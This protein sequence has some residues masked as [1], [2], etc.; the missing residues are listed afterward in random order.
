MCIK[1]TTFAFAYGNERKE[2]FAKSK[3]WHAMTMTDDAIQCR[4][5]PVYTGFFL[6]V[7]S[8]NRNQVLFAFCPLTHSLARLSSSLL[9]ADCL[10]EMS[11]RKNKLRFDE[12]QILPQRHRT[13]R[14]KRSW[15]V[16]Y[17]A[18]LFFPLFSSSDERNE[19]SL[20]FVF[21]W[22]IR[23]WPFIRSDILTWNSIV[24]PCTP[25]RGHGDHGCNSLICNNVLLP[26][27]CV[28]LDGNAEVANSVCYEYG[29]VRL[30]LKCV[31]IRTS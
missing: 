30:H 25:C 3:N 19:A 7:V 10:M 11:C 21:C 23:N 15:H 31:Y 22:I 29:N 12:H 27:E 13:M 28:P 16:I 5:N 18:L 24:C 2:L 4:E 17:S 26:L 9:S 8:R 6:A 14:K 1:T 20:V